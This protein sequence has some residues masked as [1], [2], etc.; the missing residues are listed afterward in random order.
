MKLEK[1]D[2]VLKYHITNQ[3][4]LSRLIAFFSTE[5]WDKE[6]DATVTHAEMVYQDADN[7]PTITISM[8]PPRVK[9]GGL[10]VPTHHMIFRLKNKPINF[11]TVFTWYCSKHFHEPYNYIRILMFIFDWLFR[12]HW[13]TKHIGLAFHMVCSTFV[14]RFYHDISNPCADEDF[15][16]AAPDDIY[17]YCKSHPE[18]FMIVSDVE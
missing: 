16:S 1:G 13:F 11:D 10:T 6:P 18:I 5:Y 7:F 15:D 17:N 3:T 14:A 8:Q 9:M 2:I 4:I 12:T